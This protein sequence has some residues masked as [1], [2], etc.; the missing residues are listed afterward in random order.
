MGAAAA[1]DQTD[2]VDDQTDACPPPVWAASFYGGS[3][4]A[5][6]VLVQ[7][8]VDAEHVTP[9]SGCTPAL[10]AAQEWYTESLQVL[11]L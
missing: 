1:D 10:T 4:G 3:S 9:D 5:A 8:K 2:D 7:A 11:A 6:L